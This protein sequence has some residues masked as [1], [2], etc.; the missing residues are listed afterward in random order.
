MCCGEIYESSYAINFTILNTEISNNWPSHTY[1]WR[2][3]VST[4]KG[5]FEVLYSKM[6]N[7]IS[8]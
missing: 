6:S 2:H 1:D 3:N 8:W 5:S 4:C 7:V